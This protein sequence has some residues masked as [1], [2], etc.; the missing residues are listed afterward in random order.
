MKPRLSGPVAA[1]LLVTLLV[2]GSVIFYSRPVQDR[3][4]PPEVPKEAYGP[5]RWGMSRA[6]VELALEGAKLEPSTSVNRY[7][8]PIAGLEARYLVLVQK[9]APFLGRQAQVHYV[10]FDDKLY[11]YHVTVRDRN[12]EEL[13]RQVRAYLVSRFGAGHSDIS[14]GSPLRAIWHG[15]D[16]IVNLWIVQ[17]PLSLVSTYDAVFGVVYQPLERAIP[18]A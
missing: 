16:V 3:L 17:S 2:L 14:D 7:Y 11:A 9:D 10:F 15:R 8:T 12:D 1:S 18:T 6:E 13:D 4:A 5:T